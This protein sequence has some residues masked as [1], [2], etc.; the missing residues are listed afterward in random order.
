[1]YT[2]HELHIQKIKFSFESFP[3]NIYEIVIN[4]EYSLFFP[5]YR[6]M[7]EKLSTKVFMNADVILPYITYKTLT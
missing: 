5:L 3:V 1:M 6:A 2:T 7:I 4:T